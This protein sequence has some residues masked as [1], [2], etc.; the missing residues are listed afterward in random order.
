MFARV[1]LLKELETAKK[2]A[3]LA[4]REIMAVYEADN[5]EI[6]RKDDGSP[7]TQADLAANAAIIAAL[8]SAFPKDAILTEEEID[9]AERL[10]SDRVWIVDPLDGT[11]EFISRN[12]EFTVNIALSEKGEP[13]VGAVLIPA[14]K[15]LYYGARGHGS[16]SAAGVE[17]LEDLDR[18]RA[19][20]LRVSDRRLPAEM[21]LAKSR[22]HAGRK[23][24]TLMDKVPFRRVISKGSSLKG[25]LIAAGEAD[26]YFR[27]GP[28]NEWDIC[29][30]HAIL[31][32]AGGVLTDLQGLPMRY[33]N[34]K[35]LNSGFVASNAAIHAEWIA[36]AQ[37]VLVE[38]GE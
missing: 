15:A 38:H 21:T 31:A 10:D 17:S 20:A 36:L 11:K 14:E 5:A 1:N 2:A 26:V 7:V 37:E 29:A 32:E 28:T 23:T 3:V 8:R 6:A 30:M 25:C 13:V 22:S 19:R 12:G 35:T 9:D 34:P 16:F 24:Q 33:N 4:G 27:F 18:R